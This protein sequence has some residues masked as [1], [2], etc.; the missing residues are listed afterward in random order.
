ML[1]RKTSKYL[2]VIAGPTAVGKTALAIEL[3]KHYHSVVLSA[4]SRQFYKELN[5]GTAKPSSTQLLEVPHY[6]IN[7]RHINELYGAG[8][9]EKDALKTLNELFADHDVVFMVGG[10]GLYIDAVLNGVD[11]FVEVPVEMREKL[12]Q[13]FKEQG[14][15]WLQEQVR[16]KDEFYFK[17]VDIS[18]PQRLIRALE[19]IEFTGRPYSSFLNNKQAERSFTAIKLLIN[20]DRQELYRRIN[21]RVDQMMQDGLLEE[22]KAFA[23]ARHFNALKTVG[24]KELYEYLD[25]KVALEKAVEKIKQ[26]TRNYAKRQLTWF[27]NKDDFEE[28]SPGDSTKIKAYIDIIMSH[29]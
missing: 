18:N 25:E 10:S 2:V 4:D 14:L 17:Q 15:A 5:I 8:H 9:F 6:F 1:V 29:A 28:F 23:N 27:R 20:L 24:Y 11:D 12:N 26:H 22:V 19:V 7:T 3:A 21:A 16:Q 13:Q